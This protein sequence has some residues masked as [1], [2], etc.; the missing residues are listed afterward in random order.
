M[1]DI[2]IGYNYEKDLFIGKSGREYSRE[3]VR[4]RN[5]NLAMDSNK[6]YWE[7]LP[8]WKKLFKRKPMM[9]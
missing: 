3:F 6:E 9:I 2:F 7:S 5:Y 8:W 4:N 1:K